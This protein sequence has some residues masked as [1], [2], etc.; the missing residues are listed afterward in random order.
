MQRRVLEI[1]LLVVFVAVV[2]AGIGIA[3]LF[4]RSAPE[5]EG[6]VAMPALAS[7]V[8]VYRD[9]HGVPHI[10]A[11]NME[12]AARV[13]GYIHAD[14]RLFQMEMQ[15]RAGQGRLSEVLG[16]DMLDV[17]QF[18][19]TLGI[20]DLAQSSYRALSPDAQRFFDCY[21]A[22]VNLWLK[23]H[24]HALPPEFAAL[25]IT[26][27]PWVS[28]DSLVWGRLMALQLSGN[29][30][31]EIL[32]AHLAAK[33]SPDQMKQLFAPPPADSPVTTMPVMTKTGE[34]LHVAPPAKS[35]DLLAQAQDFASSPLAGR[36]DVPSALEKLG[37]ITGLARAAS[38]EWAISGTRTESGK[39]IL[40][41]D[42]HLGLEAPVLWY[43]A[44]I[45]TPEVSLEGA[46]VP[47]LPI[48]LLGHNED[49]AWGFTTTGSDVQDLFVETVDPQNPNQYL[50]PGGPQAFETRIENIRVKGEPGVTLKVRSTRHGP[51][52]SDIDPELAQLAGSGKVMA[53]AFTGLNMIDTTSEALM[54]VN[55][56]TNWQ[57]FLKALQ[58]YQAPPQNI[59]Y[60]DVGGN[61]GFVGAGNVPVRKKGDASVPSDGST[62]DYDWTE[63]I[64]FEQWPQ[65]YN[66]PAGFIFN[67]NNAIVSPNAP[68]FYGTDWE[69]PFRAER[70]QEIF[71]VTDKFNLDK[72]ASMQGD[73]LST[74]AKQLL[75]YLLKQNFSDARAVQAI[76]L[77]RSWD[78]SMDKN[79]AEP[80]IFE[81]W[82]Y[83][84]H[85][86][87]LVEKTGDAMKV[88]GP[89]D[90]QA[91]LNILANPGDWCAGVEGANN[92]DDLIQQAFSYALVMLAQRDGDDMSSWK[93]GDEQLTILRHKFYSHIPVLKGVSDLSVPSSG[94]YYTLDRGGSSQTNPDHPFERTHGAGFR[95]IYDLSDLSQSRFMIATGESGH[96]FSKFYGNL[97]Q[98]WNDIQ[99]FTLTG[100]PDE[101]KAR[102]AAELVFGPQMQP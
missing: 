34:L 90:A 44:R 87:M 1:I 94:D 77:L 53:L 20:Y 89:F 22:G 50:T 51:V 76:G 73:I 17:D 100:S 49:I 61:I 52:L 96:I 23:T 40:A 12:D 7:P 88:E 54:R 21:A 74:A 68:H 48:V 83:Q 32:R 29:Y 41:N 33:L 69:E 19:R 3:Y 18:I 80:L 57:D 24:Q 36:N 56:A 38:N 67:A 65:V 93:W 13:L 72:A 78:G 66:P 4:M 43:L 31:K 10:F 63:I 8:H 97:I 46:T 28:A 45:V 95:G 99:S 85:K 42:P 75:P 98:P 60:A 70:L 35:K 6:N 79:H 91:I 82:L 84:L 14:E 102:G 9:E 11:A 55:L 39:P 30:K 59:V 37:K 47:G 25:N 101:L 16:K 64:P 26:P 27:D 86:L 92:C 71:N 5:Y 15:R 58:L 2:F 62:D 81:A